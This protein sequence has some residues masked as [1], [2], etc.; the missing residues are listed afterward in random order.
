M[1]SSWRNRLAD[2]E[3]D[4]GGSQEEGREVCEGEEERGWREDRD[5]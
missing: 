3:E 2:G 5:M 1:S 4:V